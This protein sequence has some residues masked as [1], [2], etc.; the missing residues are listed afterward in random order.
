[1]TIAHSRRL[2]SALAIGISLVVG[3]LFSAVSVSQAATESVAPHGSAGA[4]ALLLNGLDSPVFVTNAGDDRLFI[5]ERPGKIVIA[6]QISGNWQVTG[7]F[8]D[9]RDI[10]NQNGGEQGLLG[11]AFPHDYDASGLFYVYFVNKGGDEVIAK[12]H[13][14]TAAT[15]DPSSRRKLLLIHDP[16]DNHNGGWIAFRPGEPY[17]YAAEGDGG[18]GGDPQNR[19]QNVHVLLGKI[20]RINPNDPD[21]KGPK[22]YGIPTDNPF[23]GKDGKD[24]IYAF[25]VRNPWRD[26]FDSLTGDLWIGDVGQNRFEEVDHVPS[27]RGANFGWNKLEGRPSPS[28][29]RIP[30]QRRG[31]GQLRRDRWLRLASRGCS[32]LRA[33]RLRRLL[34]GTHLARSHGLRRRRQQPSRTL[35][36]GPGDQLIRRRE[37]RPDLPARPGGQPV[38]RRGELSALRRT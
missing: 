18:S 12:Y 16:Y 26:S 24:A 37:R 20:L 8:L 3:L 22:R 25:G 33:V 19:A 13:R 5:V 2:R 11:L 6:Q 15:A 4:V 32:A 1:M 29:D 27:G 17:L 35:H 10:V 31:C 21:G 34:L 38:S 30:A 9:I 7:T 14:S 23:V 28:R 36:V